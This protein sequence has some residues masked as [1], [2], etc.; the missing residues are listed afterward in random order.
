MLH[1]MY[2]V[3]NATL[4]RLH[5]SKNGIKRVRM[6]GCNFCMRFLSIVR[7]AINAC[8]YSVIHNR[9]TSHSKPDIHMVARLYLDLTLSPLQGYA[10]P[11]YQPVDAQSLGLADY[12]TIIKKPMDLG[13]VKVSLPPNV[14][15]MSRD[16]VILLCVCPWCMC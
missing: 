3:S 16:R 8:W 7:N 10:W 4:F 11:F 1:I 6:H 13:T 14:L 12:H 2:Q 15:V 5:F 9:S